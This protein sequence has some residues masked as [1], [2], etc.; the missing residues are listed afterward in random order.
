MNEAHTGDAFCAGQW[1]RNPSDRRRSPNQVHGYALYV[2][3]SHHRQLA[4]KWST[5]CSPLQGIAV[6]SSG[7]FIRHMKQIAAF[8]CANQRRYG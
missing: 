5:V 2:H 8:V 4:R 3:I 6:R 1:P 7:G